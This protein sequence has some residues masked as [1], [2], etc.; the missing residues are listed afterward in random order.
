MIAVIGLGNELLSDEGY[1]VYI[2]RELKKNPPLLTYIEYFE[3]GVK[4]HSL[5]PF[6]FDHEYLIFL[7]VLKIEDE[8]GSIYVFDMDDVS[9]T[10]KMITSFHDFGVEDIYKLAKALGSRAKCYVVGIVPEN[11]K[12]VGGPTETLLRQKE[13]FISITKDLILKCLDNARSKHSLSDN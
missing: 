7:D 2:L 9:F 4:G 8:P 5:L 11:I 10:N 3:G 13:K 12:D 6:F 1:G